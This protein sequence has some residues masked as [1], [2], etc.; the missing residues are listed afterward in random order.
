[1]RYI[2]I[3]KN[4]KIFLPIVGNVTGA[5]GSSSSNLKLQCY[6]INHNKSGE[7]VGPSSPL[8]LPENV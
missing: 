7:V 1:L 6:K 8:Y 2:S 4:V 3:S 5:G